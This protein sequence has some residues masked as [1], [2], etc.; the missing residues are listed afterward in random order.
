MR[1]SLRD[2]FR[3]Q[4]TLTK[5]RLRV[6]VVWNFV[7]ELAEAGAGAAVAAAVA[8]ELVLT[9]QP[10]HSSTDWTRD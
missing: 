1:S 7:P 9:L 2:Y 8:G 5:A 6:V 10:R 4:R 3:R